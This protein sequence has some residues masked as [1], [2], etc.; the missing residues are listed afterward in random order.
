MTCELMFAECMKIL[1][2]EGVSNKEKVKKAIFE[3]GKIK[4][5]ES[6]RMM[7]HALYLVQQMPYEGLI[8]SVYAW[9]F[10]TGE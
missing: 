1:F 4:E 7:Y 10:C 5:L 9:D 2:M 6:M 8:E 3:F